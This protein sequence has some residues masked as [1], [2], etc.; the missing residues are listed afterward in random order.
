M[1]EPYRS[2]AWALISEESGNI[3]FFICPSNYFKDF[4]I[5]KTGIKA[6][7]IHVVPS[8]LEETGFQNLS[9][10]NN[11]PAIGFYS[12]LSH[13]NGLDKL[14][15]A[16]IL[17][18]RENKVPSLQLHL[19]GGYTTDNK[20]FVKQQFRKLRESGFDGGVKLYSAFHGKQE[21]EFFCSIDI[22]SV[23]VRKPDAYGLYLLTA[24]SA[25]VPV[26]QP[27]T[28]AFPE[29]IQMT[30]GG[31]IYHPD[32]V[33]QLAST[34]IETINDKEKLQKLSASGKEAVHL[35][36]STQKMARDIVSLYKKSL[37]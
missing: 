14:I 17:I 20:S 9:K 16:Y 23:P 8:G 26:V 10:I 11:V 4:I 29:I 33:E 35:L 25:G 27:G 18:M 24:N 36:L 21:E 19:C 7:K 30:G 12:R 2:K 31:I 5:K 22:M 37:V 34:L 32:S 6:E 1:A 13:R 15:D 3:D 28:G